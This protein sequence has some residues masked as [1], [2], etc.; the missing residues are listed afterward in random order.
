MRF[1]FKN[2]ALALTALTVIG[3]LPT[4]S[5]GKA[6][7]EEAV[8]DDAQKTAIGETIKEYL[9]ENP[10]VIFDAI[11]KFRAQEEAEKLEMA[12]TKISE[13]VEYLTN[14]D[15]PSVGNPNGD[16]TVI[17]FFDYNCGYCKKALT[18][19]QAVID[20]DENVRVV[21]K[22]LPIL[23]PTSRTAALWALAAH[24][25]GKYFDYHVAL[26]E[27][28]GPKK[29]AEL[30]KLAKDKGLDVEQMK[31]DIAS[32]DIETE[33]K[34]IMEVSRDIGVSGTPAFII[35]DKFIPGYVGESGLRQAIEETRAKAENDG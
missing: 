2:T 25:Q 6:Q 35:G 14:A 18:D 4:L 3:T 34:N 13:N 7:A 9:M 19:I 24:K 22:E 27:H 29:E 31:K 16:V 23:G 30:E 26:M 5:V 1:T 10:K 28:K 32:G 12:K 33:L 21:F 15:A 11:D 8:F 17:E 20:N